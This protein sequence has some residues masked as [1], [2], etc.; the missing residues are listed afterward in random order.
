M[1]RAKL[2]F[3]WITLSVLAAATILVPMAHAGPPLI[4]WPF[5]IG[6]AKSLP[7]GSSGWKAPRADYDLTQLS[8]DTLALLSP[9]TPVVVRMET[10]RRATIYASQNASIAEKLLSAL[11][12]RAT[13][14]E[15]KGPPDAQAWFDFG[16]LAESYKQMNVFPA[17]RHSAPAIDGYGYVQKAIAL[18]GGDPEM[19]FAA[20]LITMERKSQPGGGHFQ[21]AVAGAVDGSLLAKNLVSHC[22][23]LG[24]TAANVTELRTQVAEAKK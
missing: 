7:W 15:A 5:D 17:S 19:E 22:R 18:R 8:Q 4:C 9:M 12:A 1:S 16:Y 23:L 21:K 20:A 3:A 24:L 14:A 10:M 2:S 6:N 11:Q 13:E